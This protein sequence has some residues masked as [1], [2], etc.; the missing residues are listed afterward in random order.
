MSS[1]SETSANPPAE[2][3]DRPNWFALLYMR[4]LLWLLTH[5]FYRVKVVGLENLPEEGGALIVCNHVSLLDPEFLLAA[6]P[7][8]VRFLMLKQHYDRRG[9]HWLYRALRCIPIGADLSPREMIHSLREAGAAIE[10]GQLVGIFAE[11]RITRIGQ[12]LPFRQGLER[13]MRGRTQPIIPACLTN[14]WGSIFS[15]E[16]RRFAWKLPHRVPY[17]VSISFGK[18]MPAASSSFDVRQAVQELSTAAYLARKPE[19]PSLGRGFLATAKRHPFRI[20][21]GDGPGARLRFAGVLLKAIFLTRRLRREFA[22]QQNVGIFLPPCVPAALA[23]LAVTLA[24][25]TAVNLNYTSSTELLA[26]YAQQCGLQRIITSR[27]FLEKIK[28]EL[29]IS[30]LFLEDLA[31]KPGVLE[32]IAA[33]L[34][35]L[36]PAATLERKLAGRRVMPDDI[37]TIVFS[38]GSSGDPKGVLLTHFNIAA[39]VQQMAQA[40]ML[41]RNDCVAGILPFF[42]CFGFSA[43]IWLPLLTGTSAVYHPSPLEAK[44]I[45]DKVRECG[46]TLLVTTPTFMNGFM[47]SCAPADFGSL[48]HVIAGAEKLPDRLSREFEDK[49]GIRP[50]EGYGCTECS[51]VI[52]VNT[53]HFRAAGVVQFGNKAGTVGHPLPGISVRVVD[54]ESGAPLGVNQPGMLLISGPN[55]MAGYLNKPEATAAVLQDG[56]YRTG[57]IAAIDGEG[58]ITIT[59]RASRFSKIGGE[60]V[61]HGKIEQM[62][63][64]L[65]ER[66]EPCFVVS[67]VPDLKKGER[68]I[69]L[70]TLNDQTIQDCLAKLAVCDLPSLW[71]PHANQFF[72]VDNIPVLPTGKL[73]LQSIRQTAQKIASPQA[74][75]AAAQ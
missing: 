73:D 44:S 10:R 6:S 55:V 16:K 3:Q 9:L 33:V 66:T 72:R 4:V 69:V 49:F 65:A 28:I 31:A 5:I 1:D 48:K 70:H 47:R 25:K 64:A 53:Q 42:H 75:R 68:L 19:M 46:I 41:E 40:F 63:Q 50:L 36:L 7:R 23:N 29:P 24:G 34:L 56:W 14:L 58:F 67:S 59:D 51:P 52:A 30:P 39:N 13:I 43:T 54:P 17:P 22:D 71:K 8:F 27:K 35:A 62:L 37:A 18:P 45:G 2:S 26:S 38:S 20:A 61:P 60:M 32:R 15:F 74:A 12:M 11:G 21:L 57:D